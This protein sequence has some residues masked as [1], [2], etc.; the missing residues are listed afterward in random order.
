MEIEGLN[1]FLGGTL[2]TMKYGSW[3]LRPLLV[4]GP[5][6]ISNDIDDC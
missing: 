3:Q 2:T 5:T 4:L 6:T 1:Y